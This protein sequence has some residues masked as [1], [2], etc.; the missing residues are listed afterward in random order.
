MQTERDAKWSTGQLV[1]TSLLMAC[2]LYLPSTHCFLGCHGLR[3]LPTQAAVNHIA[4]LTSLFDL[5]NALTKIPVIPR[6]V[7]E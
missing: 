3:I 7:P 6:A 1:Y 4:K 5:I 2:S